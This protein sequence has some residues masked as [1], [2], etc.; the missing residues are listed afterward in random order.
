MNESEQTGGN[1]LGEALRSLRWGIEF[2]IEAT[3]VLASDASPEVREKATHLLG[4]AGKQMEF[5]G[6]PEE[7]ELQ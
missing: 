7:G 2:L 6:M 5:F 3:T 1:E 4:R